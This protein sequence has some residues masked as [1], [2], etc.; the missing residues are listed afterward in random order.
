MSTRISASFSFKSVGV[1]GT[2]WAEA[3]YTTEGRSGAVEG[4]W[5]F[6][7]SRSDYYQREGHKASTHPTTWRP[8]DD[9]A[10]T[11]SQRLNLCGASRW[12]RPCCP[13]RSFNSLGLLKSAKG[14]PCWICTVIQILNRIQAQVIRGSQTL[15]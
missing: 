5:L 3:K 10:I 8:T 6:G 7:L 15:R 9:R 13:E 2:F 1:S 12:E 11:K 4:D 14:S